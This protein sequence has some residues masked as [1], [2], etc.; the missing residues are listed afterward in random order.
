MEAMQTLVQYA[1]AVTTFDLLIPIVPA[2]VFILLMSLLPEPAR[3]KFN[4]IFVAGAGAAYLNGGL[5][6]W[7]FVYLALAT[8][9]AYRGLRSYRYIALAWLMHTCWDT[10]HHL[11][12]N[13]ILSFAP[14]SSLGCAI[15]DALMAVWFYVG[16]PSVYARLPSRWLSALGHS[17]RAR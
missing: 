8:V 16:A 7:E 4:A 6:V 14:T 5:G 11:Y 3:Q 9:V 17:Q 15:C 10:V 12:G 13:P 1:P 2:V